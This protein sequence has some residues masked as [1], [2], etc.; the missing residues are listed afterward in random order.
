V[1]LFCDVHTNISYHYRKV[2][3]MD[4]FVNIFLLAAYLLIASIFAVAAGNCII[5]ITL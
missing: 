3:E 5:K 2:Y 4:R 1:S